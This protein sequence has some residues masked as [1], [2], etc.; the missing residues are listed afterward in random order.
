MTRICLAQEN[1]PEEYDQFLRLMNLLAELKFLKSHKDS[2][3]NPLVPSDKTVLQA[4]GYL[5]GFKDHGLAVNHFSEEILKEMAN[6][7]TSNEKMNNVYKLI[8]SNRRHPW[9]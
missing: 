4:I 8:T 2:I 9:S 1:V 7:S 3:T 5:S 6:L